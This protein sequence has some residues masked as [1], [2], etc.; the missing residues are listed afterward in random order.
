MSKFRS[1]INKKTLTVL[2]PVMWSGQI[3]AG[4]LVEVDSPVFDDDSTSNTFSAKITN[5]WWPLNEGEVWTY[6]AVDDEDCELSEIAEATILGVEQRGEGDIDVRVVLDR[7]YLDYD[8]SEDIS[9]A[10]KLVELTYDWYA[11]DLDGR[12]WY[13]GEDTKAWNWDEDEGE[14]AVWTEEDCDHIDES[15]GKIC[16]DGNWEDGDD[17]LEIGE[18]NA[19]KGI[20]MLTEPASGDFYSQE[21]YPDVAED[22]GKVLNFKKLDGPLVGKQSDCL[23]TKEW[24]PLEPG[25]IEHKYYCYGLGLVL[26]EENAGGK[27]VW[28]DL[29]EI[30]PAAP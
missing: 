30:I 16:L 22:M 28:V 7:E 2:L 20:I 29:V 25:S 13:V 5:P 21:Y 18:G 15:D 1:Y 4:G 24:N 11:Q 10:D 23:R 9:G 26:V 12:V 6:L 3:F 14:Y 17:V 19:E 27:T 8:C